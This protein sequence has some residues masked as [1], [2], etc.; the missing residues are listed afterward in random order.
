MNLNL[1]VCIL[2]SNQINKT[3]GAFRTLSSRSYFN[4]REV[5]HLKHDIECEGDDK[6]VIKR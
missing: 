2:K 6:N 4:N 1:L 5:H 3:F